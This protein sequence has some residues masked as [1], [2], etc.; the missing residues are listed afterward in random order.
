[1]RQLI[2]I[3]ISF[4]MFSC[5]PIRVAPNIEK[6]KLVKAKKFK[7]DLPRKYGFVFEDPKD[8]DEFYKFINAKY[9]LGFINVESNIPVSIDNNTYFLSF[10]E[11][12]RVS[13]TINLIPIAIDAGLK[14]KG[15][16][17]ILEDAHTSRTGR[18]YLILIVTDNSFKDCLNPN[19]P[20]QNKII[21]YLRD[22][23]KEYL[24]THNYIE[25]VLKRN[26]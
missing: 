21:E 2:A 17:T 3:I 4:F 22:L 11:R 19:Y 9:D 26:D 16:S 15:N 5:I 24:T 13:K 12:E 10:Y 23:K 1:M 8:S 20:N 14:S 18:W 7:R 25:T 6:D